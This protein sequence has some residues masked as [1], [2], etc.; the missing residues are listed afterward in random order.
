[1]LIVNF[2][3]YYHADDNE[4]KHVLSAATYGAEQDLTEDGWWVLL[5]EPLEEMLI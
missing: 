3:V 1:M 4:S 2:L 5:E